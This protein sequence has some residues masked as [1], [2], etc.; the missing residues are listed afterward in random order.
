M[1]D[2]LLQEAADQFQHCAITDTFFHALHQT[3]MGN[4]VEVA[5]QVGI[6][7]KGISLLEQSIDFP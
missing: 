5:L 3:I 2:V 1:Q 6:Y 7:H 4:R